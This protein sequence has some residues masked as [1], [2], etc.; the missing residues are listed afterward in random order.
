MTRIE[1]YDE[2]KRLYNIL[3]NFNQ[4]ENYMYMEPS[5]IGARTYF[6]RNGYL[7]GLEHEKE[8]IQYW[9]RHKCNTEI[10]NM[11]KWINGGRK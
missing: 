9:K 1:Y 8:L 6:K 2:K 10:Q 4:K 7:M 5:Y 3:W 11:N